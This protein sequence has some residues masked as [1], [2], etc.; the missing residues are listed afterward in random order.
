MTRVTA[1]FGLQ[2]MSEV[3]R[4]GREKSRDMLDGAPG[5]RFR[6]GGL[7]AWGGRQGGSLPPPGQSAPAQRASLQNRPQPGNPPP[8]LPA[9]TSPSRPNCTTLLNLHGDFG[10]AL[11]ANAKDL[12]AFRLG[13][14]LSQ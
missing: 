7:A 5:K 11:Q 4:D 3:R 13:L 2:P 9:G 1:S 12:Y 14:S 8:P 10:T 6:K